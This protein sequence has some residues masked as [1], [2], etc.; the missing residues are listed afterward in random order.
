MAE[1]EGASPSKENKE[2]DWLTAPKTPIE[3]H[4][5]FPRAANPSKQTKRAESRID[6]A[7]ASV[8]EQSPPLSGADARQPGAKR[9]AHPSIR[10]VS[11]LDEAWRVV[12]DPLQWILQR[13]KGNP[14]SKNS[15]WDGRSFCRTRDAL[16]RCIR[17][18][19]GVVDAKALANVQSLPDWHSDWDGEHQTQNLDVRGTDQ[20]QAERQATPLSPRALEVFDADG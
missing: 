1:R 14:R 20:A 15:G 10:L 13:R 6:A 2:L 11:Q 9:P 12:D 4:G 17:E 7:N 8:R 19:C 3:S 5:V 16:L 18:Y